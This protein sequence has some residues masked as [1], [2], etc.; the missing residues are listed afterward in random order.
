[1]RWRE[2]RDWQG[3][4]L[5]RQ[6]Y[7]NAVISTMLHA[8]RNSTN[9]LYASYLAKWQ[10]FCDEWQVDY[11]SPSVAQALSF[12]QQLLQD[13]N[14]KRGYSAI[15]TARSALSS[16]IVWPDGKNFGE[17]KHVKQFIKGVF[18]L[19]PPEPRYTTTWDSDTMISMLKTWYPAKKISLLKLT[20][21]IVM[22]I[23]L[24]T[25]QR[26]QIITALNVDRM[27]ISSNHITF[28][29][30]NSDIKQGRQNYKPEPIK[31][32][33]FL[34]KRLC[35]V[36]YI[37][38]YLQ[39]TLDSRG[40]EKQLFLTLSKPIRAASRDTISRWVKAV[41]QLAGIDVSVF[42][43]GSTRSVATS[44]AHKAGVTIDEILKAGAWS[45]ETTFSKWYHRQVKTT[46]PSVAQ[47]VLNQSK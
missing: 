29:I 1:M 3:Q 30:R 38:T 8:R 40:T 36:H 4:A 5:R 41:M 42:K 44:K 14:Q 34:D 27:E 32:K 12:L 13:P 46:K 18:N 2:D 28:K 31:L 6:G 15:C 33:A 20:Q 43:P 24:I 39:R 25:G 10:A 21:K 19:S 37:K 23:L 35:I 47:A 45:T 26:G 11:H 22:L 16:V 9:R 7:S 17:H